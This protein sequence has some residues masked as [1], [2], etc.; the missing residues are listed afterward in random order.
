MTRKPTAL[1]GTREQFPDFPPRDDMQNPIYLHRPSHIAAPDIHYYGN[2][3]TTLVMS[4][5]PWLG[6]RESSSSGPTR[7][8]ARVS[9]QTL[10]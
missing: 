7:L 1:T 10:P 9:L 6:M 4:E 5:I 3:D 8:T 2:S